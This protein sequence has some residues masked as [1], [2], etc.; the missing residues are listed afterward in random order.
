MWQN[1][2][3]SIPFYIRMAALF[4]LSIFILLWQTKTIES[5][6]I[7]FLTFLLA[8]FLLGNQAFVQYYY[9]VSML[10]VLSIAA[11]NNDQYTS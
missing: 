1:F 9:S 3:Q 6:L 4:I 2:G 11:L 8:L 7:C 10:I 5:L